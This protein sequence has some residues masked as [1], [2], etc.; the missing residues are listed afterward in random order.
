MAT[1]T[2]DQPRGQ[3]QAA[4]GSRPQQDPQQMRTG[5]DSWEQSENKQD[6]SKNEFLRQN[7][8]QGST[9]KRRESV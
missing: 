5:W 9:F 6:N 3:E 4:N 7:I 2:S 8:I 1:A